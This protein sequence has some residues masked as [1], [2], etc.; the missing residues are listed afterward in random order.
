MSRLS[1]APAIKQVPHPCSR[2]CAGR[3]P[4]CAAMCYSWGLYVAIRNHIYAANRKAYE[5]LKLNDRSLKGVTKALNRAG[6]RKRRCRRD[7]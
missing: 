5:K 3:E 4:G 1:Y 6:R 2:D 7:G